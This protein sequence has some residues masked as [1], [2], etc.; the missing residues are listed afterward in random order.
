M[1][2]SKLGEIPKGWEISQLGSIAEEVRRNVDPSTLPPD[3]PY[4][5][6]SN[7]P[8]KSIALTEWGYA[9][10]AGSNKLQFKKGEIL[11]GKIRPYFHKVAL[12]PIDGICSGDTIIIMP[13]K[14]ELFAFVLSIVSSKDFVAYA[15]ASSKGTKMP[16]ADWDVLVKYPVIIP[17]LSILR[18]FNSMI[19]NTVD[20]IQTLIFMN[21]NLRKVRDLLL[22]RIIS[23]DIDISKFDTSFI[24]SNIYKISKYM[25]EQSTLV[26]WLDGDEEDDS[27]K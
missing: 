20:L 26:Q 10:D 1:I 14:P 8:R 21:R 23:G 27:W 13:K 3:T 11:F 7:I 12:A 17:E 24:N 16:R 2:D 22:P 18:R 5:G 9:K 25:N 4:I 19:R 6:L 15:T